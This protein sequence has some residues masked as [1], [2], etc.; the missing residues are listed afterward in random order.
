[1]KWTNYTAVAWYIKY[2][3]GD[4]CMGGGQGNIS[5]LNSSLS[6]GWLGRPNDKV[7][8]ALTPGPAVVAA[9]RWRGVAGSDGQVC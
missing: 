3:D 6:P 8:T 2:S 9:E 5:P 7:D 1:M 4:E